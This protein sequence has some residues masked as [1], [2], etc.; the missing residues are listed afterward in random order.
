AANEEAAALAAREILPLVRHEVPGATLRLVGR[1]P[2]RAVRAL[3]KLPGVHVTGEV[4]SVEDEVRRAEAALIP[5]RTVRGL[6]NK[7]LEAFGFGLPVVTTPEVLDAIGAAGENVALASG[8][9]EG[10]AE[11]TIRVLRDPAL[12][13]RLGA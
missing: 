12:A 1:N 10:M 13:A 3:G 2:G 8:T 4:A 7:V 11:A 5:L 9:A 6:P